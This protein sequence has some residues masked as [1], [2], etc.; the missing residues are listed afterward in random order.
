MKKE[1][2][3]VKKQGRGGVA[4]LVLPQEQYTVSSVKLCGQHV[5]RL[6]LVARL[7]SV[8]C[9]H[10]VSPTAVLQCLL[11]AGCMYER[12]LLQPWQQHLWRLCCFAGCVA[13]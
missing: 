9:Q 7:L 12:V 10:C 8:A 6:L 1:G 5:E 3:D 13:C 2:C 4:A 11:V